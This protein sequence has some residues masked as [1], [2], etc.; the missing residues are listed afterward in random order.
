VKLVQV[1]SG[2][3]L[4]AFIITH[5]N[6]ALVS[7]LGPWDGDELGMGDRRARRPVAGCLEHPAGAALCAGHIL[8]HR[9]SVLRSEQRP[10]AHRWQRSTTRR[11]AWMG[12]ACGGAV[13]R[14]ITGGLCGARL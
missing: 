8:R 9:A 14:L 6:S 12:L 4:A 10:A 1:G 13:S 2:A 11:V 7:A 5:L 3:Y